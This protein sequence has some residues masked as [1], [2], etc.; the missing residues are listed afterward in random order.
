MELKNAIAKMTDCG[1]TEEC[2]NALI[3]TL[4]VWIPKADKFF[5]ETMKTRFE[6]FVTA[7]KPW[8]INFK[9]PKTCYSNTMCPYVDNLYKA[10]GDLTEC[11]DL[12]SLSN[13]GDMDL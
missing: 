8:E 11:G 3:K 6:T 13:E 9:I 5:M 2:V 4:V 10:D 12:P 1:A 7:E